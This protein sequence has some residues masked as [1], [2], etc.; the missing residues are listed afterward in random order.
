M[1]D[2]ARALLSA[3]RGMNYASTYEY[4]LQAVFM[5][6]TGYLEQ[7]LKCVCWELATQDYEYRFVR[8]LAGRGVGCSQYHDKKQI[9]NDLVEAIE[10]LGCKFQVL[11]QERKN[12]LNAAMLA[13]DEF[14]TLSKAGLC[15]DGV[16]DISMA[17]LKR[18]SVD[19][20]LP[21]VKDKWDFFSGDPKASG[22]HLIGKKVNLQYLYEVAVYRHRNRCAHN[23]LCYQTNHPDLR[24]IVRDDFAYQNYY[25]RLFILLLIDQ[26]VVAVFKRWQ[27]IVEW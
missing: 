12:I 21:Q 13:L 18:I 4:I 23:T 11:N 27:R 5:R 2:S 1:D 7:K 15:G 9:L 14:H 10:K 22:G 20:I 17:L 19:D 26:I 25:V 8:Y 16:F 6:M 24:S 3:D